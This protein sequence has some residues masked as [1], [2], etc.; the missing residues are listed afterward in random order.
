M[1]FSFA[2]RQKAYFNEKE[3]YIS[4]L[5]GEI[6]RD[7]TDHIVTRLVGWPEEAKNNGPGPA[8]AEKPPAVYYEMM[9]VRDGFWLPHVTRING[10]AY[11]T[12]F[13]NFTLD[14]T[15]TYSQYIRFSTEVE[16][17]KMGPP[18]IR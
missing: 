17:V 1:I 8:A 6:W 11:P 12:L 9:R 13:N 10:A 2:P 5:T 18:A 14:A 16:G 15:S 7:A 3:K 4:Q